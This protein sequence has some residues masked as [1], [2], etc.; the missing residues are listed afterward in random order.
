MKTETTIIGTAGIVALNRWSQDK[1]INSKIVL[2]LCVFALITAMIT[3][4]NAPLGEG[5]GTLV[6]A[7]ALFLYGPGAAKGLGLT[8]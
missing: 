3:E 2:G 4:A 8:K 6:F 1:T 5:I 7:T